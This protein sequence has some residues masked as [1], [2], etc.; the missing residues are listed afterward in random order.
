[1][2][3]RQMNLIKLLMDRG[4]EMVGRSG[5][6]QAAGGGARKTTL[7]DFQLPDIAQDARGGS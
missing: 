4:P 5:R 2:L 1:M 3:N 6:P 7:V